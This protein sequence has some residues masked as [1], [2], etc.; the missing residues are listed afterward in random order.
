MRRLAF[1]PVTLATPAWAHVHSV[2]FDFFCTTNETMP[3]LTLLPFL[4]LAG[5]GIA[6]AVARHRRDR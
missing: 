3:G 2:N 5:I 4:L 1:L 6:R